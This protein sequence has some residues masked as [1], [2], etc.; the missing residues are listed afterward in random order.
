MEPLVFEPYLRPMVWGGRR[1][2]E[3]FGKA[4]PDQGAFGESWEISA[5]P[6]HVSRVAEGPLRGTALPDLCAS[7]TRDLFG[8]QAPADGQL[9]LLIKLLDC[10]ELLSIQVHPPDALASRL[11]H[12][13]RGKTE[14]WIVLDV[15]PGGRIYAG[16]KPG[17]Q[18]GELERHLQTGTVDQC[19]HSFAPRPGDCV[20]LPAGTV[21]A[22]GGGVVL[23][24]VQQS[25]DAT[26]R[27]FDWNRLGADGQPRPLHIRESL[28]AIDWSAGPVNPVPCA[29]IASL[30][31]GVRG[32]NL[33]RC[34]YFVLD[35]FV[36]YQPFP[37]PYPGRLSIW[38]LMDGEAGLVSATG[39]Y[40]RRFQRGETVLVP[41]SCPPLVWTP[42]GS[43]QAGTWM[44]VRLPEA[45]A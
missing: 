14:A 41:A 38:L 5:H 19:L 30:P 45:P 24:E 10:R 40:R 34:P 18:R 20:Y 21:H 13:K 37:F 16:L 22:V 35:R 26:F 8:D 42:G 28:E 25:S 39:N 27:L 11:S 15:Q 4:L 2:R 1:L 17:V 6:H 32:D 12:E 29:A 3:L 33:V 31:H 36:A 9:P 44:R 7:R 43:A 23:A